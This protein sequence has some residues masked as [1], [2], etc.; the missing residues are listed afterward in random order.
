MKRTIFALLSF[1]AWSSTLWAQESF[2]RGKAIRIIIGSSAGGGYDLWPR[3]VAP[4]LGQ[5]I[6]GK[7]DIIPQNMPGAGSIVAANYVYGVA[8]PAGL[9]LGAINTGLYFDQLVG[10][11]EGR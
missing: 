11:K 9:T 1:L 2:Y 3:F 5:Y 7:P 6:P 4:Y 10:R 8:K